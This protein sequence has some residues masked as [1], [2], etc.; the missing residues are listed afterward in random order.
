VKKVQQIW[1]KIEKVG[2][3]KWTEIFF[4]LM[5]SENPQSRKFFKFKSGKIQINPKTGEGFKTIITNMF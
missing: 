3:L 4:E 1:S 2:L 5:V